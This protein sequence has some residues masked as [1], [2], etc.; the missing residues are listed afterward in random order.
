MDCTYHQ[1]TAAAGNCSVCG[2]PYCRACL[3]E[4]PDGRDYCRGCAYSAA[5]GPEPGP[6]SMAVSS[7]VLSIVSIFICPVT[8]IPGMIMGFIEMG[9]IKR[10][11]SPPAGNGFALAGAIIGTVMT[12]LIILFAVFMFFMLI[13]GIFTGA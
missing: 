12:A 4:A 6:S 10:G 3:I 13:V 2:R 9:K 7:M 1:G 8:A 5:S 11:Q